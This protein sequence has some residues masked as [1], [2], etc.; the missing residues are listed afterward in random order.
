MPSWLV[1]AG[2]NEIAFSGRVAGRKLSPGTYRAQL[3]V[4]D[5]ARNVS[6]TATVSFKV[7]GKKAKNKRRRR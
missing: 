5:A 2:R 6:R 1:T 7:I 3:T 4:T